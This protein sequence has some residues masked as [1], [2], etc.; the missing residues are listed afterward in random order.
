M[1]PALTQGLAYGIGRICN[2]SERLFVLQQIGP[3]Q[4]EVGIHLDP[5][6]KQ[7]SVQHS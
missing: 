7:S 2:R 6:G 4:R 1:M 5:T 3:N